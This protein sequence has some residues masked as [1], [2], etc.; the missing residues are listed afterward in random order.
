MQRM[1]HGYITRCLHLGSVVFD[2]LQ[3]DRTTMAN[4]SDI[5]AVGKQRREAKIIEVSILADSNIRRTFAENE[6]N[7]KTLG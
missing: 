4:E 1:Q 6:R 3:T 5:I 7:T 2:A